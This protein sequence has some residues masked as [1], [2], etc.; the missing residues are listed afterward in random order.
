MAEPEVTRLIPLLE[1]GD[2]TNCQIMPWGSN[3]TFIVTIGNKKMRCQAV[4]KPRRGETPLWDF[5]AGTLYMREYASYL[6]SEALGWSFIPP[7]TIREGPH[8]IGSLQLYVE[9][10]PNSDYFSFRAD[11][12]TELMRIAAFDYLA[13]NADRKA[14]HCV[15]GA[16]GKVWGIDHGLTFHVVPK[17][18]T[19]IWD[20]AEQPLPEE[21]TADLKAF[22]EKLAGENEFAE[23]LPKLLSRDEIAALRRRAETLIQSGKFPAMG[24]GRNVPWPL[25]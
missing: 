16:N 3:Y 4:Y 11:H 6:V 10:K 2:I 7:T 18:R 8:G 22:R 13:N 17:L 20:F 15:L 12:T 25:Y 21:I 14:G 9:A 19:V 24:P 1:T 23:Q 5:P